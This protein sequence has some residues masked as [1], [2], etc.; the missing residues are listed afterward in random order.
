MAV[1]DRDPNVNS[2]LRPSDPADQERVAQLVNT[3]ITMMEHGNIE[4]LDLEYG[5]LKLSL[6]ARQ[7]H[8]TQSGHPSTPD[9]AA[10][11][12]PD[13]TEEATHTITA[14]MIGTFYVAPAPNEPPFVSPGDVVEQGQTVG[15]IE[16]MKIMNEIAADCDGEVIEVVAANGQTVE[17]GSPLVVVKPNLG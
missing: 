16:A 13:S 1:T 12:P 9:G 11:V 2:S 17:Y 3:F 15:I 8:A 14:P 6:R 10:P 7:S 4:K 5:D